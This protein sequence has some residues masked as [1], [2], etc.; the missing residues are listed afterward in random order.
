[1]RLIIVFFVLMTFISETS[2]K[3]SDI[4]YDDFY[5]LCQFISLQNLWDNKGT[6]TFIELELYDESKF[7]YKFDEGTAYVKGWRFEKEFVSKLSDFRAQKTKSMAKTVSPNSHYFHLD[8][9]E[10]DPFVPNNYVNTETF[11]D[12]DSL[13]QVTFI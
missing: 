2:M 12:F 11:I 5:G 13:E 3:V 10:T 9:D 4:H 1:M 8:Y 6:N 7:N